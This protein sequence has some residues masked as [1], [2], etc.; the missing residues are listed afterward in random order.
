M[1]RFSAVVEKVTIEKVPVPFFIASEPHPHMS[2]RGIYD[3]ELSI[4]P[5]KDVVRFEFSPGAEP[6][7][8]PTKQR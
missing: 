6:V 4:T 2:N 1:H 8:V 3:P 7:V 5:D